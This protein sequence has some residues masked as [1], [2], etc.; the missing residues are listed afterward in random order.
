MKMLKLF[1][2]Y[3]LATV[4]NSILRFSTVTN[5]ILVCDCWKIYI[6]TL[7]LFHFVFNENC[8]NQR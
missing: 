5:Q 2:L 1:N 6:K 8:F 3:Y 4:I 7:D